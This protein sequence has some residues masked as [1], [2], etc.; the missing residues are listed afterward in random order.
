MSGSFNDQLPIANITIL[1]LKSS[2][3]S[4][5]ME[6]GD[7]TL[8]SSDISL[9]CPSGSGNLYLTNLEKATKAGVWGADFSL[10]LSD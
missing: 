3:T 8:D 4:A 10:S 6:L 5:H 1:G 2:P 9:D 7:K